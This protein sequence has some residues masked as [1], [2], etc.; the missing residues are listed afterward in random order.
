MK[1]KY[2]GNVGIAT[3]TFYKNDEISRLK[4]RLARQMFDACEELGYSVFAV[5]DSPET[6]PEFAGSKAYIIKG[7]GGSMG[8]GRRQAI[9]AASEDHVAIWIEPEKAPLV[10]ELDKTIQPLLEGDSS[11][12]I[13]KRK[14]LESYPTYQQKAENAGNAFWRVLTGTDLDVWFGPRSIRQ[15][16][17]PFFL[18]Y[19]GHLGDLWDSIFIPIMDAIK[20]GKEVSGIEVDYTHP[21]EQTASEESNPEFDRKRIHQLDNLFGSLETHWKKLQ[22]PKIN[23]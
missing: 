2:A 7:N 4:A 12:V 19:D 6:P 3:T 10:Q 5:D 22:M 23:R 14:S 9:S 17:V 11:I 18:E 15:D 16:A 8:K 21:P 1:S 20:A 13:P